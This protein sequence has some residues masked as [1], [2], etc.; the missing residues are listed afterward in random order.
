MV[1]VLFQA[2]DRNYVICAHNIYSYIPHLYSLCILSI[3]I[4]QTDQCIQFSTLAI[5]NKFKNS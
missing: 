4:I 1:N 5:T 3:R 2:H